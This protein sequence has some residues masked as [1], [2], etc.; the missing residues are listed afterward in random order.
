MTVRLFEGEKGRLGDE[1]HTDAGLVVP[2][3]VEGVSSSDLYSFFI[4]FPTWSPSLPRGTFRSPFSFFPFAPC[5]L[6][7]ATTFIIP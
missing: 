6:P 2:E 4:I 7:F 1:G 3:L 5:P